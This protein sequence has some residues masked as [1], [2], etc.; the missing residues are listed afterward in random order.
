MVTT[1]T[2]GGELYH[3]SNWGAMC[4]HP[5]WGMAKLEALRNIMGYCT[6]R[7]DNAEIGSRG[8]VAILVATSTSHPIS[9]SISSPHPPIHRRSNTR[10]FPHCSLLTHAHV[11]T[12]ADMDALRLANGLQHEVQDVHRPHAARRPRLA[13]MMT[14][15]R[16]RLNDC[17]C[18]CEGNGDDDD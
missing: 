18:D 17:D 3:K 1:D 6:T 13:Q 16:R 11:A 2:P 8:R 10:T 14:A 15:R 9:L 4:S 7:R 5:I 12:D